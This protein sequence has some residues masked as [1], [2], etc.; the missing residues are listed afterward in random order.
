MRFV[1]ENQ[2][3]AKTLAKVKGCVAG[4]GTIPILS[5]VAVSADDGGIVVRT[6]NAT[7]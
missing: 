5:H 1:V 4:R 2:V 6:T 7:A 3:F